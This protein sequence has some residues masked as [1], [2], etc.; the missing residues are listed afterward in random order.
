[1]VDMDDATL[2][3]VALFDEL[4]DKNISLPVFLTGDI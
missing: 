4:T 3:L 1:M 2:N